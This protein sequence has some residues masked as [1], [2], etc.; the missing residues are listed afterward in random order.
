MSKS[1]TCLLDLVWLVQVSQPLWALV[2]L[3]VNWDND[4]CLTSLRE[5]W[6]RK[7]EIGCM[8]ELY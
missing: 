5:L 1:Q 2:S 7:N 3:S 4:P 6:R 8:K